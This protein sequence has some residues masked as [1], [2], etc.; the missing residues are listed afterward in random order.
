MM[1][2]WGA[3][4]TGGAIAGYAGFFW[5]NVALML[6]CVAIC[7]WVL[8]RMGARTV[9]FAAAPTLALYA[10]LNWDLIAVAAATIAT[11]VVVRRRSLGS[12]AWLGVG[13]AAKLYPALLAIPFSIQRARDDGRRE[14]ARTVAATILTW[15]AINLG[16]IVTSPHGWYEVFRYNSS[17]GAD[18]ES[19]WSGL[20]QLHLCVSTPVLNLLVPLIA[21]IASVAVWR[22]VMRL[23]PDTPP[24]MLGFPLLV[25]VVVSAKFWSPQYALW[26]LPWFALS[27]IPIRVWLA[28]QAAEVLEFFAR[29]S[30]MSGPTPGI[31]LGVL[32]ILVA[33]RAAMLLRC[34][35]VWMREPE[36]VPILLVPIPARS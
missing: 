5:T 9:L 8:E 32:S 7:V 23:H 34:L 17:R 27:R 3:A 28:Y 22:R 19:L 20:C 35:W 31:S 14:G 4:R 10:T 18:F 1:V 12:G 26:L 15:L 30:F 25:I 24:W 21:I 33:F 16:F 29:T 36:P 11:W 13:A 6:A 2:M